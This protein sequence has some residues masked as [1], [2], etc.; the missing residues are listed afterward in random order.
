[1]KIS[2]FFHKWVLGDYFCA[3]TSLVWLSRTAMVSAVLILNLWG[4]ALLR[5]LL[6]QYTPSSGASWALLQD[7]RFFGSFPPYV[8]F[9][10]SPSVIRHGRYCLS[11][12]M[13]PPCCAAST[14]TLCALHEAAEDWANSCFL[15]D[16]LSLPHAVLQDLLVSS[17]CL[18]ERVLSRSFADGL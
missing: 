3:S 5:L 2:C 6:P 1:M 17:L 11:P 15:V 12:L 9:F 18:C 13:R 16:E 10:L 4:L 7:T 8:P 14:S